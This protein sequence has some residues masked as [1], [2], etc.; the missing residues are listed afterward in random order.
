MKLKKSDIISPI[1]IGEAVAFILLGILKYGSLEFPP[2]VDGVIA[3]WAKFLPIIL[4]VLAF[5]G[6]FVAS[7]LAKKVLS[8]FQL[9]KFLLTG[10]LN[11]FVDI[12]VLTFLM[13]VSGFF[14][15]WP[16]VFFKAISFTCA[17]IN[18]YFW[19]KF[20]TYEKKEIKGAGKEFGKFYLITGIGFLLN[21]SIAS[22]VVNIVGPKF[23]LTAE[24]WAYVGAIFAVLCVFMWNFLGYKFL[25]FKK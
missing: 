2:I 5:A 19:N 16:Y 12:G 14:S 24:V 9:A 4:P 10:I 8:L 15:G 25:V 7:F 22:F 18:S 6:I 1:I 17:V 11:T 3:K 23:G 21:I 13:V 20:W